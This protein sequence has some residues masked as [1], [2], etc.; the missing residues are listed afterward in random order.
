MFLTEG[1]SLGKDIKQVAE[2][3]KVCIHFQ[4]CVKTESCIVALRC[5]KNESFAHEEFK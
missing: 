1:Y 2:R 5:C 3:L 4:Q